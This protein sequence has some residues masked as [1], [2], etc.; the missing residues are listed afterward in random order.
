[1]TQS[2]EH[3]TV[4]ARPFGASACRS[5]LGREVLFLGRI[6][7]RGLFRSEFAIGIPEPEQGNEIPLLARRL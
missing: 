5:L 4:D 7:F 6:D 3:K 2:T 1:M